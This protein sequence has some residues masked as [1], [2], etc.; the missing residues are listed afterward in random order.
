MS[1]AL[2][3]LP[4]A[5]ALA[6]RQ[7]SQIAWTAADVEIQ[8]GVHLS[9]YYRAANFF[10]STRVGSE[11]AERA[12]GH[13]DRTDKSLPISM[14]SDRGKMAAAIALSV[15]L[16]ASNAIRKTCVSASWGLEMLMKNSLSLMNDL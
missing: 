6:L 2:V 1:G 8:I 4:R 12:N 10:W 16:L 13:S 15:S 7:R 9:L 11:L 5:L 14:T 3:N